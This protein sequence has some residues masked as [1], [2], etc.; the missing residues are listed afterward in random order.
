MGNIIFVVGGAAIVLA[1]ISAAN[2]YFNL[3][4]AQFSNSTKEC[5]KVVQGEYSC[6]TLPAK[7]LTEWVK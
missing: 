7:Y 6:E 5:V 1:L 4:V 3:P 2:S